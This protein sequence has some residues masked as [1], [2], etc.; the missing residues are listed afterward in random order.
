FLPPEHDPDSYVREHGPEGFEAML[1]TAQPLSEFMLRELASRVDLGTPEG[2]ARFL[3]EARPLLRSM[4]QAALRLQLVQAAAVKA[5]IRGEDLERY[6]AA[7]AGDGPRGGGGSGRDA[8]GGQDRGRGR[9]DPQGGYDAGHGQEGYGPGG[10]GRDG[11]GQGGYG[12]GGYG[13]DGYGQG[14]Y[15][16]G[17]YGQGG[18]GPGGP[19]QGGWN[20]RAGDGRGPGGWSGRDGRPG[21]GGRRDGGPGGRPWRDRPGWGDRWRP[22]PRPMP[23]E[24]PDLQRRARLLLSLHPFLA[25]EPWSGDFLPESVLDWIARLGGL[26]EGASFATLVETLR[27]EEPELAEA[28]Q[29]EA[30]RDRG[31]LADLEPDEARREFEGALNQLRAQRVREE[32]DRLAAGGLADDEARARYAELQALRKALTSSEG[33]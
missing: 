31:L 32:V 2:R 23:I 7:D 21:S 3:A 11:Y 9:A 33:P 15:G 5:G 24:L 6:L 17:G 8:P 13:R 29:A 14:G 12:Q 18:Y 16:Q 20:G 1:S 19:G 26:P 27:G 25:R 22:P 4:P 30:A 10:P 28:L